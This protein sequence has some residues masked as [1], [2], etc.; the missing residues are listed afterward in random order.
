[1]RN[2]AIAIASRT[3][4]SLL[5]LVSC[6]AGCAPSQGT[7]SERPNQVPKTAPAQHLESS[8][9]SGKAQELFEALSTPVETPGAKQ[10]PVRGTHKI[11]RETGVAAKLNKLLSQGDA[12]YIVSGELSDHPALCL[13]IRRSNWKMLTHKD[14]EELMSILVN[15][16]QDLKEHPESYLACKPG[17]ELW[18]QA[19]SN[20]KNCVPAVMLSDSS[21]GEYLEFSERVDNFLD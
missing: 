5:I 12:E 19:V 15:K 3:I 2:L 9:D 10:K 17:S 13:V 18:A 4:A 20:S 1:M 11:N 21:K 8:A 14:K 7:D 6:L 16:I